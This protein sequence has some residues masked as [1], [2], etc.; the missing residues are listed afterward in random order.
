MT[1]EETQEYAC[2]FKGQED[3]QHYS[4]MCTLHRGGQII[5]YQGKMALVKECQLLLGPGMEVNRKDMV[6]KSNGFESVNASF[7]VDELCC[8]Q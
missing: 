6:Q 1:M 4:A 2:G 5:L 8:V 7:L 3:N